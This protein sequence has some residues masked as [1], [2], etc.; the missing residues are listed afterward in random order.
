MNVDLLILVDLFYL[1][2]SWTKIWLYLK[3]KSLK[4]HT[5]QNKLK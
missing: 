3:Y 1:K 2:I 5:K 4:I